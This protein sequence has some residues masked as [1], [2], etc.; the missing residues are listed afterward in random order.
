MP[1]AFERCRPACPFH[2]DSPHRDRRR[3]EEVRPAVPLLV[4]ATTFRA[5][6]AYVRL[7]HERRR[8]Q[9]QAAAR[10][11]ARA[12]GSLARWD[13]EPCVGSLFEENSFGVRTTR[14]TWWG[15]CAGP[16]PRVVDGRLSHTRRVRRF[17]VHGLFLQPVLLRTNDLV[18]RSVGVTTSLNSAHGLKTPRS[19][20]DAHRQFVQFA[21]KLKKR[22][23]SGQNIV[24]IDASTGEERQDR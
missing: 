9:C 13:S 19:S 4:R 24:Y 3:A 11:S 10:R 1:S 16:R 8:L 21:T 2:Q 14:R 23:A 20:Q 17:A 12:E 5:D 15:V 22:L 6:Q 7:V 18:H